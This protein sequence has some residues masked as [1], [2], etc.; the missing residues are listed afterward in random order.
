MNVL[1]ICSRNQWRSPTA[2]QLFRR[3][4]GLN[5]RSAGTQRQA[6]KSVSPAILS[7]ADVICVM[8]EAHKEQLLGDFT[9][10]VQHK[11]VHVLNIPNHYTFMDPQLVAMLEDIVPERLGLR[12]P[13]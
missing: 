4:P 8:E 6:K 10:L 9:R 13:A 5:A 12:V 2:E 7:W 1:F 3:Y 11:P